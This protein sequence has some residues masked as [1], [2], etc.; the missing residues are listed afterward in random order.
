MG[1]QWISQAKL[2]YL[3]TL[4]N[5]DHRTGKMKWWDELCWG[6]WAWRPDAKP[7]ATRLQWGN[8]TEHTETVTNRKEDPICLISFRW[9]QQK[10]PR[11]INQKPNKKLIIFYNLLFFTPKFLKKKKKQ[12]CTPFKFL[13]C[14]VRCRRG[15]S[16]NWFS[17]TTLVLVSQMMP[18]SFIAH[19][20]FGFHFTRGQ[21]LRT[22]IF[23]IKTCE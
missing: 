22:F 12:L 21:C 14:R 11:R 2:S 17:K 10:R 20:L 1:G 15:S 6:L 19:C 9:D 3:Q 4:A 7:P 5:D 23:M 8:K 16:L 13:V 18:I